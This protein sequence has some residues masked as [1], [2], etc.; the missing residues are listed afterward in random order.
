MLR[1]DNLDALDQAKD[2]FIVAARIRNET[3]AMQKKILTR[4][5]KLN[6]GQ[7]VVIDH[8]QNRRLIISYSDQRA[9]KDQYNR[10]RGLA[11]LRKQ[12]AFRRMTKEQLNN[13]GYNQFLKLTGE[14]M[15]EMDE[16][17]IVK[18]GG[19][20]NLKDYITNTD[21]SPSEIIKNYR[22]LW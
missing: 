21:L 22:Q 3:S 6:N 20:D 15:V 5:S 1:K 19:W 16:A 14:V 11:R 12:V 7:S 2:P 9:K 13:R 10:K 4:C 8:E 17:K 18:A